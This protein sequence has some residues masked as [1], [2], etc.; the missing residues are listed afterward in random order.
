VGGDPQKF[1]NIA[2]SYIG[3]TMH[4]LLPIQL[5]DVTYYYT[6]IFKVKEVN[7]APK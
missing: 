7:I 2:K 4:V 3:K 6:F 1:L 5:E